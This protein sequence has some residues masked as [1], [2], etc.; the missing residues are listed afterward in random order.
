MNIPAQAT[1]PGQ[2]IAPVVQAQPNA[3]Q[4]EV[5]GLISQFAISFAKSAGN[6]L[7]QEAV[8]GLW[9]WEGY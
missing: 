2:L 8:Q 9:G 3:G 6:E 5:K 7:G 4:H 1:G